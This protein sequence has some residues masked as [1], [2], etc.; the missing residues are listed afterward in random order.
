MSPIKRFLSKPIH[1][2]VPKHA[3]FTEENTK[4]IGGTDHGCAN[5]YDVKAGKLV[6]SLKY[7]SGGLVQSVA[8]RVN[9]F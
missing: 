4:V 5:I 1:L 8:V 7:N 2:L 6:Q 9:T 3:S